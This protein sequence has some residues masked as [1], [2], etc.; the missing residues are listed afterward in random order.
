MENIKKKL[1]NYLDNV[2]THW[3]NKKDDSE[4]DSKEELMA[5][6]YIDAYQS[7]RVSILGKCLPFNNEDG[8]VIN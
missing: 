5:M 7:V 3:R 2:I 6:C 4:R 8:D 1:K